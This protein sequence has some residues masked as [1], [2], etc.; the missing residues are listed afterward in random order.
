M[1][2]S[3]NAAQIE[4]QNLL[5]KAKLIRDF[6]SYLIFTIGILLVLMLLSLHEPLALLGCSVLMILV[7]S[8]LLVGQFRMHRIDQAL[9]RCVEMIARGDQEQDV[10]A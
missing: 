4:I 5:A 3:K 1:S 7:S 2:A 6:G 9:G 8:L 10:P